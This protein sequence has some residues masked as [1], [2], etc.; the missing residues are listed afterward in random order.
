MST[1]LKSIREKC[2]WCCLGQAGEIRWCRSSKS[3]A[4]WPLRFGKGVRG[5][6]PLKA[7]R[8]KCL[9]C[10]GGS[11]SDVRAC[12]PNYDGLDFCPLWDFRFG[13]NP[14]YSEVTRESRRQRRFDFL[15]ENS[16]PRVDSETNAIGVGDGG[17]IASFG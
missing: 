10:V 7:I 12:A 8:A 14:N 3:C 1:P 15:R 5:I 13:T 9:D 2:L 16:A 11:P 4:I 17:R 6:S